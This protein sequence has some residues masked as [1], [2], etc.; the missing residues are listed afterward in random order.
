MIQLITLKKTIILK[1]R[2][3]W[4]RKIYNCHIQSLIPLLVTLFAL[5]SLTKEI[6]AQDRNFNIDAY[7]QFLI[8]NEDISA[9]E[10]Y[11]LYPSGVFKEAVTPFNLKDVNF[12]QNIDNVYKLTSSEK[13]LLMKNGFVVTERKQTQ[14]FMRQ[15]MDIYSKDLPVFIS[16]DALL[17]AFHVSYD[18]ILKDVEFQL[19][20]PKLEELLTQCYSQLKVLDVKYGQNQAIKPMLQDVDI[21][22]TIPLRLLGK[23][24]TP[25]YN[26]N[27]AAVNELLN[28]IQKKNW[29][30]YKLFSDSCDREIDFSQFVPRGHYADYTE[31]EKYFQAMMWLGR[32]E[33]YLSAPSAPNGCNEKQMNQTVKRQIIDAALINEITTDKNISAI[34]KQM[35]EVISFFVGE[36]D[37]VTLKELTELIN[38]TE[39]L[40]ADSFLA[41]SNIQKFQT[42]LKSKS[43]SD[44]KILSQILYSGLGNES[45]KPA[46]AFMLFG[47][48]FVIDSYVTGQVVYDRIIYHKEKS[49]RLKPSTLDVLFTLGNDASTQ[50][51]IPELQT[52]NYSDNLAGL[53]YLLDQYPDE[54]WESSLYNMWLYV[55]KS[56]NPEPAGE[57]IPEFMQTSA[58]GTEKMNT[59]LASWTELRHD[60]LLYAKP[61]YTS[62]GSCL[63]PDGYVEPNPVFFKRMKRMAE[64][65]IDKFSLSPALATGGVGIVRYFKKFYGV[66]D[67]LDMIVSKEMNNQI[68]DG[69]YLDFMNGLCNLNRRYSCEGIPTGWYYDLQYGFPSPFIQ[70]FLVAD[71]HTTPTDCAGGKLGWISHAGTGLVDMMIAVVKTPDNLLGACVGPVLSYHEYVTTNFQ[72]LS[73][74]EWRDTYLY[75]SMRPDWVWNY[76]ADTTGNS[77]KA[78]L[79]LFSN[80]DELNKALKTNVSNLANNQNTNLESMVSIYPNPMT[81][82]AIISLNIPESQRNENTRLT[83]YDLQGKLI[84][85]LINQNLSPGHYLTKWDRTVPS[86]NLAPSGMYILKLEEGTHSF[87]TKVMVTD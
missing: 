78:N 34:Y 69:K 41:N 1:S 75:K 62:A 76:L 8:D 31:L 56:L 39:I 30:P 72:R 19:L 74:D 27:K 28:L 84:K 71:Y 32:T 26:E 77:K 6:A 21:Y 38:E 35:E 50:L 52:Y 47:Q 48:R 16:T 79:K 67:T 44:Q 12:F 53:R 10:L 9:A 85:I 24:V 68:I 7:K 64:I 83:L 58:W 51:L 29:E 70:D 86:G 61:S 63:Y 45:L 66:C 3:I 33:L 2:G 65:A 11:E 55:I 15:F 49:C 13:A 87:A 46:S 57:N 37:N 23:T 42:I 40:R 36:Q 60:N 81:S 17:N 59:Q 54:F 18:Q 4:A 43:W 5:L 82:S 22:F 80:I 14:N 25:Y 20:I 73:D